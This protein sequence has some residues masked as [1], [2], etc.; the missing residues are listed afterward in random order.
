MENI[1]FINKI[2]R[3]LTPVMKMCLPEN[4]YFKL[5]RWY[6]KKDKI[7]LNPTTE[8]QKFLKRYAKHIDSNVA[9]LDFND[10][11]MS[12]GKI[13]LDFLKFRGL[14]PN[15]SLFEL[16]FGYFRSSHHFI[17]Y[18]NAGNFCG[19]D[20]SASRLKVALDH[21]PELED[22]DPQFFITADNKFE[23]QPSRTFD[24]IYSST[25]ICHMPV[26]DIKEA[27]VNISKNLM[28]ENS[29]FYFNYSV[30]DFDDFV[31]VEDYGRDQIIKKVEQ[32]HQT[33]SN[34]A[35]IDFL[36]NNQG[37]Q[38]VVYGGTQFF[39]SR[40]F[41]ENLVNESGLECVDDTSPTL[42]KDNSSYHYTRVIKAKK[43]P[44]G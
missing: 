40:S 10:D 3:T 24:Y 27:L 32:A 20:I 22:K 44:N 34:G 7:G 29:E 30:L 14:K 43:R 8:P 42:P 1:K 9:N 39:H 41:M 37:E 13:D 23:F 28:H 21:F 4:L 15:H 18:L 31:G 2:V 33:S 6:Y 26:A 17:H 35:L 5:Q 11:L 12:S 36:K 19:N 16:G 25:V 38:A